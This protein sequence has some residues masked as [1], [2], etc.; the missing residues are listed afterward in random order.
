MTKHL[1][2]LKNPLTI[3]KS[4]NLKKKVI[5]VVGVTNAEMQHSEKI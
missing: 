2:T 5:N 4:L 3:Y 1:N